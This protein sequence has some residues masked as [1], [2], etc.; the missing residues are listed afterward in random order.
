MSDLS[1]MFICVIKF[2][3]TATQ[4]LHRQK[5]YNVTASKGYDTV[6][7]FNQKFPTQQCDI[8]LAD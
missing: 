5:A 1:F 6:S 4:A 7:Q 3:I 8:M 2:W